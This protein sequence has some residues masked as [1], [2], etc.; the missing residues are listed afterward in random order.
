LLAQPNLQTL[1]VPPLRQ[2]AVILLFQFFF[3]GADLACM[4]VEF[5]PGFFLGFSIAPGRSF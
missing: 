2:N 4:L 5:L 3:Q 1:F